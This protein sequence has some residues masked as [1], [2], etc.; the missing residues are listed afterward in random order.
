M[1][2]WFLRV[3][4][5]LTAYNKGAGTDGPC[6]DIMAVVASD[7]NHLWGSLKCAMRFSGSATSRTK[8]QPSPCCAFTAVAVRIAQGSDQTGRR[9]RSVVEVAVVLRLDEAIRDASRMMKTAFLPPFG[10]DN[11]HIIHSNGF[12]ALRGLLVIYQSSL[13]EPIRTCDKLLE[14]DFSLSP[15]NSVCVSL[16]LKGCRPTLF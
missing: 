16:V 7:S 15:F 5:V 1:G 8:R 9:R 2:D 6:T 3:T 11:R 10:S 4:L 12:L 14:L 13:E